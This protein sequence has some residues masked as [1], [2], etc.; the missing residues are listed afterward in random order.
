MVSSEDA[1]MISLFLMR[2]KASVTEVELSRK[3]NHDDLKESHYLLTPQMEP[4]PVEWGGHRWGH[5][6]RKETAE[7]GDPRLPLK[8]L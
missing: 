3:N 4:A 2:E 1:E 7:E 6:E 8:T 5:G